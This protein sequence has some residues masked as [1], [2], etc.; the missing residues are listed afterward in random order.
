MS[1]LNAF[2]FT[3]LNGYFEGPDP[4]DIS[5]HRHEQEESEF[6]ADMLAFQSMLLFGRKT[7]EMMVCFWPTPAAMQALPKVAEGMNR[8]EKIVFSRTMKQADWNNTR[9]V[10]DDLIGEVTRL[11]ETSSRDLTIL[12]SGSIV[13]QL[14]EAGLIDAYEI[15]IDPVALGSGSTLF[16]GL[17]GKLDLELKDSKVFRSG[18][19]LL[20]YRPLQ[21]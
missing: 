14:G 3:T 13:T 7:Y 18:V 11:K 5:W 9:V 2:V 21:S 19:V 16:K 1:K 6:S 20:R 17:K 12:G 10:S 15:M 8:A 4:G